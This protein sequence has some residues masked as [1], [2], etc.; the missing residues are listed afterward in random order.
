MECNVL[1]H[2][3]VDDQS[4]SFELIFVML[5]DRNHNKPYGIGFCEKSKHPQFKWS[6]NIH[7]RFLNVVER[8]EGKKGATP[9][10]ILELMNE[11]NLTLKQVTNHFQG[12]GLLSPGAQN[13]N[14]Q[15]AKLFPKGRPV[16]IDAEETRNEGQDDGPLDLTLSI[17]PP[18]RG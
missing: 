2:S 1:R 9:K 17:R 15:E 3:M 16:P 13:H 10:V 6:A 14:L 5:L 7:H 4:S 12:D 11:R 18:N 8:V